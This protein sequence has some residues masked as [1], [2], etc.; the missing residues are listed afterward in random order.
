MVFE[1]FFFARNK[2]F[3]ILAI[4]QGSKTLTLYRIRVCKSH[5]ILP[6]HAHAKEI[7]NASIIEEHFLLLITGT[8]PIYHSQ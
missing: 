5:Q 1:K 7:V 4:E 6:I 8:Q 3:L 2:A